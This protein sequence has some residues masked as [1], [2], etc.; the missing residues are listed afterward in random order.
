MIET[1]N[2]WRLEVDRGPDW[3]FV[4]V[5]PPVYSNKGLDTV[6]PSGLSDTI[7]DL[8]QSH[9][10]YRVVLEMEQVNL[11]FSSLLGQLI[12]LSKRVYSQGG[13]MRI[14]GLS[15]TNQDVL[16]TCRLESALPNFTNR[17][18]AVMGTYPLQ[19]R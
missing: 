1:A 2:H 5:F 13:I 11:L 7:W 14:S 18:A 4:R 12:L 8:M 16:H 9:R 15:P 19:P 10:C 17:S 3:L 6:D